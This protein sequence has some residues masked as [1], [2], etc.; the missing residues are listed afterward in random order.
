MIKLAEAKKLAEAASNAKSAFLANMSHEI[1]TPMNGVLGMIDQVI[2]TELTKQQLEWLETAHQS[3]ESLLDIINDI[4][5]LSKIEAGQ[6]TI[7]NIPYNL[8]DVIETVTDLLYLRASAKGLVL[9][10]NISL[11]LPYNTMGD[12]LRVRQIVMNLVGNAIKFTERGHVF[13]RAKYISKEPP[14]MRIEVEDTGI[15]I[16]PDKIPRIFKD[17]SQEEESTTR[18][19]GGTGLGLS[20]SKKLV[21]MMGGEIGVSS[22]VGEGAIF[23]VNL[24]LTIDTSKPHIL[25]KAPDDLANARVLVVEHYLPAQKQLADYFESWG[26]KCDTVS[27][28]KS[29]LTTL[30]NPAFGD[31][32]SIDSY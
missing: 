22:K 10:I 23:W 31:T 20:I 17:F 21:G 14:V 19:F 29:A 1:R 5:D 6:L 7:S 27:N 11:E 28:T 3:A 8:H 25:Q 32:I 16:A 15:G 13:I 18:R 2:D 4:L 9:M 26:M 30:D 12:P 24:P